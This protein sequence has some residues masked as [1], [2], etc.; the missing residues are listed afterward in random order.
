MQVAA[1]CGFIS[2]QHFSKRYREQYGVPPKDERV[3]RRR[4]NS[5]PLH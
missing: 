2:T 3:H 1:E 5:P 4:M